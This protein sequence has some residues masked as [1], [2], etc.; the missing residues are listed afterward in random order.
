MRTMTRAE[1]SCG[2]IGAA[3]YIPLDV[4]GRVKFEPCNGFLG[5]CRMSWALKTSDVIVHK[6]PI[7]E[8]I[9]VPTFR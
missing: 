5:R 7:L 8:T 1:V 2:Q 3:N 6:M 9:K 4:V